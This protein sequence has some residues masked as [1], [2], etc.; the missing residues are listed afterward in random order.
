[1]TERASLDGDPRW[2]SGWSYPAA[3]VCAA[4]R[5]DPDEGLSEAEVAAR[6]DVWGTN[7][8]RATRERPVSRILLRQFRSIVVLLLVAAAALAF[9]MSDWAE[10]VAIVAVIVINTAIGFAT[11]LR[12]TRSMEALKRLAHID[13]VVCREG[14]TTSRAA[15]ELV[16]GDIVALEEGAVVPADL[17]LVEAAKLSID[18]SSLTGES[19]PERKFVESLAVDIPFM[20]RDNMAYRGTA[21][22]RGTGRGVVVATGTATEFGRIFEEVT[23]AEP[24]QTP[25]QKR[26][27]RLGARLV[28]AVL[29]MAILLAAA[30]ILAGRGTALAIEVAI[31]LSVAAIPEGLPIVATIALA[32]GMWRMARRNALITRLSAVETLGATSII[33]TDKTGTLTENRM[34]V[35]HVLLD[36][37]GMEIPDDVAD[38][39]AAALDALLR[40]GTL[41]SNASLVRDRDGTLRRSGDPTEVALLE[42]AAGRDLWRQDL[43]AAMPELREEPFDAASKRMA[44]LHEAGDAIFVA[45]KGA[46]ES[47]VPS[48]TSVRTA[49]GERQ[50]SAGDRDRWLER[51]NGIA[52]T[53]L[54]TLAIASRQAADTSADP[55]EKLVLLGIVGLEDPARRGVAIALEGCR[56][57]GVT[58]V[59]VTGDHPATACR[60]AV[61]T[62]IV[63][64][65]QAAALHVSGTALDALFESCDTE[66]LLAAR[67]FSRVTPE[68]KLRLIDLHQRSGN[69]VAMT[70]DGV[71]DAPALKKADIGIAMGRR[72]TAVAREASAMVL[73]DD[74][75]RT[76][77]S[78]I[79]HGRAIFENIRKFVVYLLSCNISEVLVVSLATIGGAPLPLLPLQILFLNLVTDVFP[80]LALGVGGGA[81]RRMKFKPRPAGEDVLTPRHWTLVGVYGIVISVTVLGAM[82]VAVLALGFD[83]TRAITVS[84]LTLAFSQM[85]HVF[86]MREDSSHWARNEVTRNPWIWAALAICLVLI[87]AA[88]F[89]PGVN[90]VLALANPGLSGWLLVLGAS[91]IPV[92]LAPAVRLLVSKR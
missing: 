66:R 6:R 91:A 14:V 1:V 48:C 69:V 41:C 39:D 21:V 76:I 67:V 9:V 87:G 89:V 23:A 84:F 72:G 44:T 86:N 40:V 32:R 55:Y 25:L 18:E 68:Q 30:G 10:A 11:E 2:Q 59:M 43:L 33:L 29:A 64:E 77:V 17:R 20:D 22:T 63:T 15:A 42:A 82:A 8:L 26:L 61:D 3:E 34:A 52:A 19:L 37:G 24:R 35:T 85:W 62:G 49:D 38:A 7:R 65:E 57:A 51:A 47:I 79:S 78:A 90:T 83:P 80:A 88:V 92:I 45:V 12:A 5:V 53:G 75:F 50:M 71:N 46:P 56:D 60:I 13:A 4:L 54:R 73:Q 74:E 31:A 81:D 58:V 70:G 36:S 16:P 28:W 27:D